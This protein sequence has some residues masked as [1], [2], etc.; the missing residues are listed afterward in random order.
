MR[1]VALAALSVLALSLTAAD[2]GRRDDRNIVV[3]VNKAFTDQVYV[4]NFMFESRS[5]AILNVAIHDAINSIQPRFEKYSAGV[6]DASRRASVEAA[7]IG[8][9]QNVALR[10][11]R[12]TLASNSQAAMFQGAELAGREQFIQDTVNRLISELDVDEHRLQSGLAV[13]EAAANAIYALRENDGALNSTVPTSPPCGIPGQGGH[14]AYCYNP[15]TFN[16]F[17]HWP[18]VKLW[19]IQNQLEFQVPPPPTPDSKIMKENAALTF[20]LGAKDSSIRTQAQSDNA[21]FWASGSAV[22]LTNLITQRVAI[23]E[24]LSLHETARAFALG[25]LAAADATTSNIIDKVLYRFWRPFQVYNSGPYEG[26]SYY[27]KHTPGWLPHLPTPASPEYPAGHPQQ[28]AAGMYALKQ[29]TGIDTF[30]EPIVLTHRATPFAPFVPEVTF[31][32]TVDTADQCKWGRVYGGMHFLHSG[33]VSNDYGQRIAKHVV[34]N[35]LK[36]LPRD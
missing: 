12:T 20:A 3:D 11:T 29:V 34:D 27:P 4:K 21:Q 24:G 30:R 17:N 14:S 23:Q 22:V 10:E 16:P 25:Q 2:R 32:G 8:A 13:G 35:F 6:P 28:T 7:V 18:N 26:H 15:V 33:N 9:Y 19:T 31:Y 1:F 36:P 5:L